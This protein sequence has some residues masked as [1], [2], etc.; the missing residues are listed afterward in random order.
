MNKILVKS[1]TNYFGIGGDAKITYIAQ[2]I[3]AKTVCL[4]KICY[5]IAFFCSVLNPVKKLKSVLKNFA[6]FK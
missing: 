6:Q 4:K 5:G 3:N 1:F 2:K